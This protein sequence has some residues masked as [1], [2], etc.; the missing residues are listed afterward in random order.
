MKNILGFLA[1]VAI[2]CSCGK[3]QSKEKNNAVAG[4]AVAN[5]DVS[6]PATGKTEEAGTAAGDVT[7]AA[8]APKAGQ[9]LPDWDKKI[10]KKASLQLVVKDYKRY[11]GDMHALLK[12]Y[13]AYVVQEEQRQYGERLENAITIKV[14]VAQ[15]DDLLKQL[16]LDSAAIQDKKI[17]AEDVTAEIVDV[18]ARI[19]AKKQ[20]R[21]QYLNLLKQAR[22]MKD[23]LDI[24]QEVN[25]IQE[26]I[27]SAT[28]RATFLEH[29]AAYS[30]IELTYYQ[31]QNGSG[32]NPGFFRKLK[33]AFAS[34]GTG[35][36]NTLLV[37]VYLW[38]FILLALV[39]VIL[40]KR[41]KWLKAGAGTH[42]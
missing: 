15:F 22:S 37:L 33:E 18:K 21:L 40:W 35:M 7:S 30:T 28:A 12:Q 38:P 9:P 13:G 5:K 19:E 25:E 31:L 20:V 14:P 39:I 8:L 1:L 6:Q 24:Q 42:A 4:V 16:P 27:E 34:G 11:D 32:E 2:A 29:D 17:T 3:V 26:Q 41:K 23:I 10:I 36:M